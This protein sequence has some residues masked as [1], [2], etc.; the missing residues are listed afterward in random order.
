MTIDQLAALAYT[1]TV[2]A[3][4]QRSVDSASRKEVFQEDY[5]NWIRGALT[6]T[7]AFTGIPKNRLWALMYHVL[8]ATPSDQE[9]HLSAGDTS[10]ALKW[11][12]S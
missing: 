12:Q 11:V 4:L 8:D 7:H 3:R 2:T 6:A 10:N 9:P 1:I 5:V